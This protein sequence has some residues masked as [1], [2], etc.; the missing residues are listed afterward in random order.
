MLLFVKCEFIAYVCI[1][2]FV[3]H[4]EC[5]HFPGQFVVAT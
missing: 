3:S 2:C 4:R 1:W 5:L